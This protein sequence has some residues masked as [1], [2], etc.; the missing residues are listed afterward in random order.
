MSRSTHVWTGRCAGTRDLYPH[1]GIEEGIHYALG[2]CFAGVPMGT[3]FGIKLA[4]RD[5]RAQRSAARSS[6]PAVP[7]ASALLRQSLVGAAGDELDVT[8]RRVM[9]GGI[10]H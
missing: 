8:E 7:D 5:A 10:R 3:Y 2:Y 1:I 9:E 4:R 6:P